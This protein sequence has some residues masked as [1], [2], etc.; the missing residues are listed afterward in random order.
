MIEKAIEIFLE[1]IV[2]ERE[3]GLQTLAQCRWPNGLKYVVHRNLLVVLD[4]T[5]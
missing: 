1:W 5:L 4:N 3:V 2:G